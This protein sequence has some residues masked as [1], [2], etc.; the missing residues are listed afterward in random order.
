VGDGVS[1]QPR[2]SDIRA[3]RQFL[4]TDMELGVGRDHRGSWFV[5]HRKIGALVFATHC[6]PYSTEAQAVD[7]IN[8]IRETT[9]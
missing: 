2:L 5:L 7:W 1:D 8:A 6:G 4:S 3:V 9:R